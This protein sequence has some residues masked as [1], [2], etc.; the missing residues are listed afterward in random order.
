MSVLGDIINKEL[1][2]LTEDELEERINLLRRM[3]IIQPR[4]SSSSLSQQSNKDKR[5]R[6]MLSN[7]SPEE[8]KKLMSKLQGGSN[9]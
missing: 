5:L 8:L 1:S 3:R 2:D 4:Q 6:N 9:A 7:L